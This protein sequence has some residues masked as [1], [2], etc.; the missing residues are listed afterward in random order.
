MDSKPSTSDNQSH[1]PSKE[2]E[3][4]RCVQTT[5]QGLRSLRLDQVRRQLEVDFTAEPSRFTA[6]VAFIIAAREQGE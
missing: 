6:L 5:I 2:E 1:Y 4:Q 3:L